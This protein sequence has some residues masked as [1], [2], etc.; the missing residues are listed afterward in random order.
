MW[1][2]QAQHERHTTHKGLN[3][4][5]ASAAE[6]TAVGS[7]TP[8]SCSLSWMRAMHEGRLWRMQVLQRYEEVWRYRDFQAVLFEQAMLGCMDSISIWP[9]RNKWFWILFFAWKPLLPT[10]S[11]CMHCNGHIDRRNQH[12]DFEMFECEICFEIYHY[13]CFGVSILLTTSGSNFSF[14][15]DLFSEK[16]WPTARHRVHSKRRLG[17]LLD[18]FVL[19]TKRLSWKIGKI[20]TRWLKVIVFE[21]F[22]QPVEGWNRH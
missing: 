19:H 3:K 5:T 12:V 13:I 21:R 7:R 14:W 22:I 16:I 9:L 18:L 20:E 15:I 2:T 17:E 11:V 1:Q 4:E 8:S 6:H 10:T